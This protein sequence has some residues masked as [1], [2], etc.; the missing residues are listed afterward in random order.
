MTTGNSICTQNLT[1]KLI[2]FY[3]RDFNISKFLNDFGFVL[4][5][6]G[7]EGTFFDSPAKVIVYPSEFEKSSVVQPIEFPE[8]MLKFVEINGEMKN[9][10]DFIKLDDPKELKMYLDTLQLRYQK[11]PALSIKLEFEIPI[12]NDSIYRLVYQKLESLDRKKLVQAQ[13]IRRIEIFSRD[14][15]PISQSFWGRILKWDAYSKGVREK[16]RPFSTT[17]SYTEGKLFYY[18]TVLIEYPV[19]QTE[20]EKDCSALEKLYNTQNSN[21]FE[22]DNIARVLGK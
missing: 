8:T 9:P 20:L 7:R 3:Q 10:E 16:F 22:M 13:F 11:S 21:M 17:S 18:F 19:S 14:K 1:K 12:K 6:T 4:S 15:Q 2:E 5:R